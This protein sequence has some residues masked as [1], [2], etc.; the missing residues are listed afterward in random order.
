MLH[1]TAIKKNEIVV[2]NLLGT[3]LYSLDTHDYRTIDP[4]LYSSALIGGKGASLVSMSNDDLNVPPFVV[5][6]IE[7]HSKYIMTH[8]SDDDVFVNFIYDHSHFE[9]LKSRSLGAFHFLNGA[10]I[11]ADD[12]LLLSVR[13]GARVSMPGMM[14]TI[15]NIGIN[16][17]NIDK[18]IELYGEE[19]ARDSYRLLVKSFLSF[20]TLGKADQKFDDYVSLVEANH[21]DFKEERRQYKTFFETMPFYSLDI[22]SPY[23]LLFESKDAIIHQISLAIHF[24]YDSWH[25]N[26]CIAY[27]EANSLMFENGTAVVIQEMVFGN[28]NKGSASGVLFTFNTDNGKDE[29]VGEFMEK[30]QGEA[31]VSGTQTP[32][33]IHEMKDDPLFADAYHELVE[34][35]LAL[36]EKNQDIM[37]IEF[38]IQDGVLYF[39]QC[40]SAKRTNIANLHYALSLAEKGI[41][42]QGMDYHDRGFSQSIHSLFHD[43]VVPKK[44]KKP[45]YKGIPASSGIATGVIFNQMIPSFEVDESL[46]VLF[47]AE[48][49]STEDIVRIQSSDGIFTTVGGV[50]SHAALICRAMNKPCITSA[51]KDYN[52]RAKENETV[53][54]LDGYTGNIWNSQD[55]NIV[56]EKEIPDVIAKRLEGKTFGIDH[57]HPLLGC[58]GNQDSMNPV[59]YLTPSILSETQK[60]RETLEEII[61]KTGSFN[62]KVIREVSSNN[63]ECDT[64]FN[65]IIT[66]RQEKKDTLIHAI[67]LLGKSMKV[68]DRSMLSITI[69]SSDDCERV[70]INEDGDIIKAQENDGY[71]ASIIPSYE[72]V[73]L[74]SV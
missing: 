56:K 40:R 11:N 59:V 49:T 23:H 33:D 65:D 25:S 62:I 4:S 27:R 69:Y 6:P 5:I 31:I 39:L 13:S 72:D 66:T 34:S 63:G 26:E 37:D 20:L 3:F 60:T 58:L 68:K 46:G 67:R 15:L 55:A 45:A 43:K 44:G 50:T 28:K 70:S 2:S 32:R 38:T 52:K 22:E 74:S 41:D 7:Y 1:N 17:N 51:V 54:I 57:D 61:E 73:L 29:V 64:F 21:I 9:A 12:I 18:I 42:I 16:E 19:F 53:Y 10:K 48:R 24:V 35:S 14:Q 8:P 36:S 71:T 47:K 30:T